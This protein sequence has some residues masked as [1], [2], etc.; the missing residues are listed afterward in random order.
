MIINNKNIPGIY[1]FDIN[2]TYERDDFVVYDR[3]LFCVLSKVSGEV[4]KGSKLFSPYQVGNPATMED[5]KSLLSNSN[6]ADIAN[7][8]VSAGL[9][10]EVLNS[11]LTGLNYDGTITNEIT[12]SGNIV[13]LEEYTVNNNPLDTILAAPKLMNAIF[14]V[15]RK[16]I[17]GI[18]PPSRD[19]KYD[20]LLRQYTYR[21]RESKELVRVQQL[22]DYEN[23]NI[24]FRYSVTDNPEKYVQRSST[25]K[26]SYITNRYIEDVEKIKNY[27]YQKVVQLNN[28]MISL[29][30]KYRHVSIPF[31][32]IDISTYNLPS[33]LVTLIKSEGPSEDIYVYRI[34]K[35]YRLEKSGSLEILLTSENQFDKGDSS[36]KITDSPYSDYNVTIDLSYLSRSNAIV[37]YLNGVR[38]I[39][40]QFDY[41]YRGELFVIL[42]PTSTVNYKLS[43]IGLIGEAYAVDSELI[44]LAGVWNGSEM[45][46]TFPDNDFNPNNIGLVSIDIKFNYRLSNTFKVPIQKKVYMD[47][48]ST[49]KL[50]VPGILGKNIGDKFDISLDKNKL[51]LSI[52]SSDIHKFEDTTGTIYYYYEEK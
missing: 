27:Y 2:S 17:V 42:A 18:V 49:E 37:R 52:T 8:A 43:L 45:T 10:C 32:K 44:E 20:L 34:D 1:L 30:N 9:L 31:E 40:A 33:N 5:I 15:S 22:I 14:K 29:S 11:C 4:P 21:W 24:L 13:G 35:D 26:D 50:I 6:Q 19:G 47:L 25:W 7:K 39:L 36:Y 12:S 48:S 41:E 51:V 46:W 3:E 28:R 38:I 16:S 23:G